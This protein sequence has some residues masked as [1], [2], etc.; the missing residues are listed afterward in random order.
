MAPTPRGRI[1]EVLSPELVDIVRTAIDEGVGVWI[2]VRGTSMLPTIPR[3]AEVRVRGIPSRHIRRGDVVLAQ[4]PG[5]QPVLH[6]VHGVSG[7]EI[8]LKGDNMRRLDSPV[9]RS[10]TIA[11]A[12]YVRVG[13]R[14]HKLRA[15]PDWSLRTAVGR[16]RSSLAR[17]RSH[18]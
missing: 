14:M 7:D 2:R 10:D 18:G 11:L 17:L 1:V 3:V 9:R 16:W 5:G 13:T 6:R 8:T 12:D 15:R 4:L